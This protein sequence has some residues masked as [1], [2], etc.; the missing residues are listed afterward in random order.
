MSYFVYI[1]ECKDGSYYTG[2]TTDV[3]KRFQVHLSGKGASYTRSHKP[4][5]I[6]YKED[7][8]DKSAALK[9]ELEIKSL[10][11]PEK[12]ILVRSKHHD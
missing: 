10:T 4:I 7:L 9:R 5:R 2:S 8:Q 11:R 1:L 3:D 12:E 6:I